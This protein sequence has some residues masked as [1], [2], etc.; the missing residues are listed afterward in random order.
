MYE[1]FVHAAITEH[2]APGRESSPQRVD[3][4]FQA[5]NQRYTRNTKEFWAHVYHLLGEEWKHR[6]IYEHMTKEAKKRGLLYYKNFE[7]YEQRYQQRSRGN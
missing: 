7:T 1:S 2:P 6:D 3:P 5:L 4:D